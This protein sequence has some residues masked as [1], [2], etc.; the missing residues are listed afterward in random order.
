MVRHGPGKA[1]AMTCSWLAAVILAF[2]V[3]LSPLAVLGPTPVGSAAGS[4][5]I[6]EPTTANP[7]THQLIF[8]QGED[9]ETSTVEPTSLVQVLD[10]TVWRVPWNETVL[11][12]SI[13]MAAT[14]IVFDHVEPFSHAGVTVF[15]DGAYSAGKNPTSPPAK[16]RVSSGPLSGLYFWQFPSGVSR[17]QTVVRNP[18]AE[19]TLTDFEPAATTADAWDIGNGTLALKEGVGAAVYTGRTVRL[20]HDIVS[21]NV[22]WS[23]AG[24]GENLTVQVSADDGATWEEARN[25]T[26]RSMDGTSAALRW[27]VSMVQDTALNNTPV[28][29]NMS[30]KVNHVP[31]SIDIWMNLEYN[32]QLDSDGSL[33]V[34]ISYPFDNAQSALIFLG[35]FDSHVQLKVEGM[36]VTSATIEG[37]PNKMVYRHMSGNYLNDLVFRV[38]TVDDA[39]W[40]FGR[41][42]LVLGAL[43]VIIAI[44]LYFYM[45]ARSR[46]LV[47]GEE[48]EPPE[49]E[50]GEEAEAYEDEGE[51]D[52]G[53][54]DGEG[55]GEPMS[56]LDDLSLEELTSMKE[57]I[58]RAIKRA[59]G[60]LEQG[61]LGEDEHA[62]IRATYKRR[63][64]Q[65]MKAIEAKKR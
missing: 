46:R 35:Y 24:I 19:G 3:V 48:D 23:G 40:G 45:S 21:V 4:G 20:G 2:L 53:T 14:D 49:D 6:G 50:G 18:F 13:P 51:E 33:D 38:E 39:G 28:M 59:D 17:A 9:P 25:G 27:R 57:D 56:D 29:T 1:L 65:V 44:V 31:E 42:L 58:L 5:T 52:E 7:L 37:F 47:E 8:F 26:P 30:V 54:D 64:L 32:L 36:D 11:Y 55:E 10:R 60:E 15:V 34:Q 62:A 43:L 16:G 22:T 41:T 61:I 12:A 63:A